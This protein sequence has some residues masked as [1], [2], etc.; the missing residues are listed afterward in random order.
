MGEG[1]S[2]ATKQELA[3]RPS[4]ATMDVLAL[5]ANANIRRGGRCACAEV[6]AAG[7]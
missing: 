5:A 1:R 6:D 3:N 4:A 7:L 2:D